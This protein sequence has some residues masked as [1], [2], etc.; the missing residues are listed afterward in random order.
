MKSYNIGVGYNIKWNNS[1]RK[2]YYN[3][4]NENNGKS[5]EFVGIPYKGKF[6]FIKN[7]N[8]AKGKKCYS[9]AKMV[10]FI[11]YCVKRIKEQ[12]N[13]NKIEGGAAIAYEEAAASNGQVY[14]TC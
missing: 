8:E 7:N 6:K 1:F 2:N 12:K 11:K 10:H 5:K 13:I 4:Q 3:F 14:M 9:C